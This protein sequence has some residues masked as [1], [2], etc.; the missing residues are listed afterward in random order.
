MLPCLLVIAKAPVPGRSKT[1]LS[2]PCSPEQA[3]ELAEAALHDTLA[4]IARTDCGGRRVV[5]EGEP[6]A[7]LPEGFEVTP[8]SGGDLGD[9]LAHAFASVD[10]PALL[11][12]MDTPQVTPELLTEGLRRLDDSDTDAVIG[13]CPDGGYWT[14][15]FKAPCPE[16][17]I[18]VP[19]STEQ[20]ASAQVERLRQLGM[21]THELPELRDVDHFA[22]AV[23]VADACPAGRFA[24]K[25]S[26]LGPDLA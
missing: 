26:E 13:R 4:T 11:V 22:D 3:A 5:L 17:F 15:G 14:I 1:R 6:G 8:Q 19:M 23:L 24:R 20:T 12:G 18:G 9:R 7:W 2:P 21:K 25:M 16:A 10:G